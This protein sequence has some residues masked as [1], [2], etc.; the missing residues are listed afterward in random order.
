MHSIMLRVADID[1]SVV[2]APAIAVD[3][4]VGRDAT[5]DNLVK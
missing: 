2:A 5:A 1:E 4:S 3:D